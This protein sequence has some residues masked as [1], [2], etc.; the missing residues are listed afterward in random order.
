[1]WQGAH[2]WVMSG[3]EATGD[4][5]FDPAAHVTA[6]RVLDPLYPRPVGGAWGPGP[7]PDARLT[8]AQLGR[9]F[10]PYRPHGRNLVLRNRYVLV[11]PLEHT[12]T[13]SFRS[14]AV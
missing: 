12:R 14:L 6:V 11:L 8:V 10:V 2:A 4:P 5:S 7:A 1:M 13:P 9:A 3:F